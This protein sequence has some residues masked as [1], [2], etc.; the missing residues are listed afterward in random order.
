MKI[1]EIGFIRAAWGDI[2]KE[3]L[4]MNRSDIEYLAPNDKIYFE[5]GFGIENIGIGNFRPFRIDFNWRG[6]YLELPDAR[7][8]GVTVGMGLSF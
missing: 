7:K 8:F 4:E 2:S 3:S 5:Y 6:N 1:R